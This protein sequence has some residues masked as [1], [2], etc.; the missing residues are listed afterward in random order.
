[1]RE[2]GVPERIRGAHTAPFSNTVTLGLSRL[3]VARLPLARHRSGMLH[4]R[5]QPGKPQTAE[6]ET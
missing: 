6:W 4:R 1:M 2:E 3:Q 5:I